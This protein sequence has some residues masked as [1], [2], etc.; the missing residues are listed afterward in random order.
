MSKVKWLI[1]DFESDNSFGILADEVRRQGMDCE[2][3]TYT[4]LQQGQFNVF[5]EKDCIIFQGSIQVALQLQHF[6]K[7]VPGPWLTSENYQC[8]T[9]FAHLGKYLFNDPYVLL[10]R[11]EVK[12]RVNWLY[13][14]AFGKYERDLFFRPSS[15]LKTFSAGVYSLAEIDRPAFS[16]L[17]GWVTDFTDPESMIVIAP[18]KEIRGEWRFICADHQIITGCQYEREGDLKFAPGYPAEAK[19]LADQIAQEKFQPDPMYIIDICQAGE[20]RFNKFFLL[21]INSFSC[22][23][24]YACEMEP[25]VRKASEIALREWNDIYE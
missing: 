12:R 3:V 5:D 7:W 23:G 24:L 15:G 19:A 11:E 20:E 14:D 8:T 25:I 22:G 17:W 16:S 21:E 4:P 6:H 18:A 2:V 1:E 13:Y 9:Y 10:P